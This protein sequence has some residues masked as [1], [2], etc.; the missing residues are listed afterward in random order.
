[1]IACHFR[2]HLLALTMAVTLLGAATAHGQRHDLSHLDT[3][4]PYH[5]GLD[6][7]RLTTPQ[8]VGEPGVEAVVI[9]GIDD[10]RD[11][12]RYEAF[13]RPVL[14]RL[15]KIDG[16]APVSIMTNSVRPDH[17]QLQSWLGEGL[18][19]EVHTIDH[20]CPLLTAGDL[21]RAKSTYD[22]CVDL[23]GR[24]PGNRPVAF[25]MPCCDSLNTVSPRFFSEIFNRTTPAGNHLKIDTSIFNVFTSDDPEIPRELVQE[26]DGS[27]R[28]LKYLPHNTDGPYDNFVNTIRN[29]PYPYVINR[30]CWEFPCLAPSDWESQNLQGNSN[31]RLLADWKAAL[32]ITVIKQGVMCLVFHPAGWCQNAQLVELINHAVSKHGKKVKF[33]N[34]REANDRMTRH[35]LGGGPGLRRDSKTFSPPF[36]NDA[37]YRVLDINRDGYQDVVSGA[38][39][40]KASVRIWQPRSGTWKTTTFRGAERFSE[41]AH[42]GVVRPNGQPSIL[43]RSQQQSIWLHLEGNRWRS[44]NESFPLRHAKPSSPMPDKPL[45][46]HRGLRLRDI[47]ND[48]ID[49]IIIAD[50]Q[51]NAIY[52]TSDGGRRW[53][54][55]PF[56]LPAGTA[57]TDAAG[58]DR[59]LRFIDINDDGQLDIVSSNE[60]FCGVWLFDSLKTGWAT[61]VMYTSPRRQ[62]QDGAFPPITLANGSDNGFFLHNGQLV[63]QNEHTAGLPHLVDRRRFIDLLASQTP[64][65]KS[66]QASMNSIRLRPGFRIE[67]V[68]AEPLVQDPVAMD[69]GPDGK[70]WV[71]EMGDYPR[72]T[73]G[74]G[75]AGG[76]VRF[77]EDTDGD[78]RYDSSTVFLDKLN[79]P[80]GVIAWRKGILVSAA[81][82]IFY[83]EDTD[84]DGRADRRD[85]LFQGFVEGNQQHRVNGFS[86]GLDNWIY[87][88]NGDSGGTIRSAKT[89]Q[90]VN[91]GGRDFRIQPDTGLID[92]QAGQTQ[93][94]RRRDDW[95]NWFGCNNS[96]PM[97]HFVLGDHYLRRNPH[98]AAPGSRINVS[99][100]PGAAPVFPI[101]RTLARYND[102]G[103][104]NRF[105][106]ACSPTVYRDQFYGAQFAGNSF[107]CEPVHN[108]IHRERMAANQLTFT[109]RRATDERASEFLSSRDNW[110]RPVYIRTGPDG[111]LWFADMYRAVIEHPRWI[112]ADWQKRLDLRA[113]HQLGRIYR[114]VPVGR[115]LRQIPRL[116]QLNTGELVQALDSPNGWQRDLVQELLIHRGDR[117]AI[118]PLL[119]Q[120]VSCPRPLGRL[121]SMCAAAGLEGLTPA[122]VAAALADK[123]PGVRRHAVR[124]AETLTTITPSLLKT[125]L[126]L[127]EDPDP[128]VRLQLAFSSGTLGKPQQQARLLAAQLIAP[129]EQRFL[130]AALNSSLSKANVTHVISEVLRQ[131]DASKPAADALL[132]RLFAL[133]GSYG[134]KG[135]LVTWITLCADPKLRKSPQRLF[136]MSATLLD[137]LQRRG[138]SLSGLRADGPPATRQAIDG[139]RQVLD[140]ARQTAAKPDRP[141]GDRVI[142]ARLLGRDTA[143]GQAE[144]DLLTAWLAPQ[145]DAALQSAAVSA[146]QRSGAPG[147]AKRLIDGWT[148]Y[149]PTRR[150]EVL[151]VLLS[152]PAW[153]KSLLDAM[154]DETIIAVELDASTRQR[155]IT[156]KDA[157]LKQRAAKLLAVNA[158]TSRQQVIDKHLGVLKRTGD[159]IRG[160]TVFKNKCSSCHQLKGIGKQ[161]GA[162][163]AALKD[164][165][166]RS[167]LTA[168]L[169]PNRAVEA[170]FLGYIAVTNSGSIH[171]GMLLGESSNSVR[172]IGSDGKQTTI[173]RRDLETLASTR[174]SFMPE[175]LEKDL[176][177]QDL[178]DVMAFVTSAGT[179]RKKFPGNQPRLITRQKNGALRLAA[180][181]CE[182]YGKSL[183]FEA[184]YKNL[185]YWMSADD[186]AIWTVDMPRAGQ[187]DV[188]LVYA[189]DNGTAGN[190]FQLKCDKAMLTGNIVGTGTW[191]NYRT[192]TLGRVR[193]PSGRV[194]VLIEPVGD[195]NNCLMDLQELMLI[196]VK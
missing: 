105:T 143:D 74:K 47:D 43:L 93:F 102:P 59:G 32:D 193:L 14:Q 124:L 131:S 91:I 83:A 96:N 189:C 16:R 69:W 2:S 165:S 62:S 66:P 78:G 65:P 115:S 5:V 134:N 41:I 146:L 120:A 82:E 67:L 157:T 76:R 177:P 80:N 112:P 138:L 104:V 122:V 179:P 135:S 155:L 40:S 107:V 129:E 175:G 126:S 187:Y 26:P 72:G 42:F 151:N 7:P 98:L 89:G 13:L 56:T 20:P 51:H 178:A 144:L 48:G 3:N 30:T 4:N 137:T 111:C 90:S 31:P 118:K 18:S 21:P 160:G 182:I 103:G 17:P 173:L 119:S 24:I 101:S 106:S 8:W 140:L 149:S 141:V 87:C 73:D 77:L 130:T 164:K 185:G 184:R 168:I 44:D 159:A 108:L 57:L 113:G 34:F 88:A 125:L 136:A 85:V 38:S 29:Y 110:F 132:S 94:G 161:L 162:D 192:T 181:G 61:R 60:D 172:L 50:G 9:L 71:V 167:L 148:G 171:A 37:G 180:T 63:W 79:F 109:S 169:D 154:E 99:V 46:N 150:R 53:S 25:R 166:P 36:Q 54:K 123:H 33:L 142:A 188:R 84:G 190:S 176:Q 121:H 19:I 92:A 117:R 100:T 191:D 70:L 86:R 163:L 23:L 11:P 186:R 68:A 156:Q 45:V 127:S 116:D 1:M 27:E 97:W 95:G 81:P 35:F 58:I 139:F 152:R 75:R 195:P 6:T 153:H 183:V 55:L 145:T 196:P 52:R 114:I 15:K 28:F 147:V 22:R 170:K 174:L 158:S 49:E 10:M 133:D 128:Q 64:Q 12:G 39:T 194:R